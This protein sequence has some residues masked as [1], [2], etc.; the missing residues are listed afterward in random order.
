MIKK[1]LYD[2]NILINSM[3]C[4]DFKEN[5]SFTPLIT[6][7]GLINKNLQIRQNQSLNKIDK[8]N[9]S[10]LIFKLYIYIYI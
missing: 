2:Y 6:S 3:S 4:N 5:P 8:V 10:F 1:N 9:M 7:E